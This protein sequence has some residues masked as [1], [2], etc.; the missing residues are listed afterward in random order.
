MWHVCNIEYSKMKRSAEKKLFIY[1]TFAHHL[2]WRKSHRKFC[3]K[4]HDSKVH[5]WSKDSN[6]K[7]HNKIMFYRIS[8]GQKEIPKRHNDWRNFWWHQYSGRS[9]LDELITSLGS[10]VWAGKKY[11]SCCYNIAKVS[12]Y[13]TSHTQP[14]ASIFWRKNLIQYVI[15]EIS[16]QWTSWTRM[17]VLFWWGVI[18]F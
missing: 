11:G 3:R 9:K 18:H 15:F 5:M 8:T 2:S 1:S 16:I 17:H 13:K 14:F 7:Y 10:S 4:H 12:P 6:C